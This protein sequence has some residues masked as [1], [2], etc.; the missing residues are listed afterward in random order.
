MCIVLLHDANLRHNIVLHSNH[1]MP[2]TYMSVKG[3]AVNC[4]RDPYE[5]KMET[6]PSIH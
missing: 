4:Q 3:D 5:N 2:F 6:N 1:F